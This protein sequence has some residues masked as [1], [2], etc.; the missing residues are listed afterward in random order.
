M[1]ARATPLE[2]SLHE[3]FMLHTTQAS[4]RKYSKK[5]SVESIPT[6]D[7]LRSILKLL[8]D[9]SRSSRSPLMETVVKVMTQSL[10]MVHDKN[11]GIL[12][13]RIIKLASVLFGR[14]A[15]FRKL[16][17]ERLQSMYDLILHRLCQVCGLPSIS[18]LAKSM[19]CSSARIN[20]SPELN[21]FLEMIEK[22]KNKFGT[23]YPQ[24]IVGYQ[25]LADQ[26]LSFPK[27]N[28]SLQQERKAHDQRYLEAK[29]AQAEREMEEFL[30]EMRLVITQMN[31]VFD[32]LLPDIVEATYNHAKGAHPLLSD[33]CYT[34]SSMHDVTQGEGDGDEHEVVWEDVE[35]DKKNEARTT[36]KL[37]VNDMVQQYGLGSSEY[38][39]SISIN[40]CNLI[41]KN[42]ENDILFGNLMEGIRQT[43]KRFLPMLATWSTVFEQGVSSH[44]QRYTAK[45]DIIHH[46]K[47]EFNQIIL[48]WR[49][50]AS[51][52]EENGDMIVTSS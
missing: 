49:E 52:N 37:D 6:I 46:F 40:T 15:I 41:D 24:L 45:L 38:Q 39:I 11:A 22:W 10:R 35:L 30:P 27:E 2:Q 26:G 21:A 14:S 28:E 25:H 9:G 20:K 17:I 1:S 36:A 34:A 51:E 18:M 8:K 7:P 29:L 3:Y 42:A 4:K 12:I 13:N 48:K 47:Q 33:A 19:K 44:P 23:Q 5:K 43:R 16:V 50:V 32:I 31:S